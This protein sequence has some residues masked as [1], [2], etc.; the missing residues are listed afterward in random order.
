VAVPKRRHSK[1]RK[2]KRRTHDALAV[3]NLPKSQKARAASSRSGR[4]FCSNCNQPKTPHA[5]C[6]NCGYYRGRPVIEVER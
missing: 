4:F 2:R 3:P 6:P 5:V 1:E